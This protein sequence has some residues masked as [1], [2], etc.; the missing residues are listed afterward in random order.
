MMDRPPKFNLTRAERDAIKS[1]TTDKSIM[2]RPADKQGAIVI[3]NVSDYQRELLAQLQD[4]HT[5]SVLP[6]DPTGFFKHIVDDKLRK[7]FS[8]SW[9]TKDEFGFL[10]TNF[11]LC[12]IIYTLPKKTKKNIRTQLIHLH[13]LSFLLRGQCYNLWQRLLIFFPTTTSTKEA[14]IHDY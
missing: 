10:T 8:H 12:P 3:Q 9:I 5:N 7:G 11:H 4:R 13:V 14:F 2:T 6:N 1:L